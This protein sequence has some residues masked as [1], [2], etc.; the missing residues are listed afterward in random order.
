MHKP[1]MWAVGIVWLD[2]DELR[3]DS[4]AVRDIKSL[5][6][7]STTERV[8]R[9]RDAP[10]VSGRFECRR[11]SVRVIEPRARLSDGGKLN[12]EAPDTM[13]GVEVGCR[14]VI[15]HDYSTTPCEGVPVEGRLVTRTQVNV[16]DCWSRAH[17]SPASHMVECR[18]LG[19]MSAVIRLSTLP[20]L[21]LRLA[22]ALV[23]GVGERNFSLAYSSIHS[24]TMPPMKVRPGGESA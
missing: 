14:V 23:F 4:D 19:T 24:S 6:D 21:S 11:G 13:A 20:R 5:E 17:L 22:S 15:P 9:V 16:F 7:I 3:F 12:L 1:R 18:S 8:A 2:E 10:V